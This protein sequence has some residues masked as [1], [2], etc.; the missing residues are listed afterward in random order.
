MK[1]DDVL[2]RIVQGPVGDLSLAANGVWSAVT[3]EN[4]VKLVHA[5]QTVLTALYTRFPLKTRT[6][7]IGTVDG[8]F[9]YPL[10]AEFAATSTS[11]EPNKF[12]Q[13]SAADPFL[14]DV[15]M[16]EHVMDSQRNELGLNDR[17]DAASWFTVAYDTLSMDY[18]LTGQNYFV[19]YRANHPELD[20]NLPLEG[21]DV[22]IPP[23]LL[24][25]LLA[26]VAYEVFCTQTGENAVLKSQELQAKYE[27]LCLEVEADNTVQSSVIDTRSDAILRGGWR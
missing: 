23:T 22:A 13:D 9:T 14:G 20:A 17:R 6:L 5:V 12:I 4:R 18:P 27:S 26:G 11:R 16:I 24:R 21:Q 1:L 2:L 15:L 8:V 10:R 25:A 7:T 3:P 19:Q